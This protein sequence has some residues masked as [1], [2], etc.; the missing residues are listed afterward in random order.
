MSGRRA[1]Q[2]ERL[3][4]Y[5]DL[6]GTS[7]P[8]GTLAWSRE[9]R[10]AYFEFQRDFLANP[11][12]VSPFKLATTPGVIPASYGPFDGL[13]GL[14]SDS[15]PDGWG[16][17]LLDRRLQAGGLDYRALTPLDR[18][19]YVGSLGMGA[20]RYEPEKLF[21]QR[22]SV[23]INLDVI[24]EQADQVQREV[25][26][27]DISVLLRA[28]GGSGGV[29]PKLMIGLSTDGD[30]A[31]ADSGADLPPGFARWIVKFRSLDETAGIGAEEYAYSL[32]ARAAGI[33]MAETRLIE[34]P[35]GRYFATRRFDRSPVGRHHVHTASGLLETS[36]KVPGIGYDELLKLTLILTRDMTHVGQMFRRMAFNVLAHN[37]DDHARNHAF[38]MSSTGVWTPSPAY[39]LTFSSGPAG[40]HNLTILGEGR[41][42]GRKHMLELARKIGLP[43]G[44]AEAIITDIADTVARWPAFADQAGLTRSR[45]AEISSVIARLAAR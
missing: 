21:G 18:L 26:T 9:E 19:A 11:L 14:F 42:P 28:Q 35:K 8:L 34:T 45:S 3:S 30:H 22:S 15:L 24:A 31:L 43:R 32:M 25:A 40:E 29:R 5:L 1:V 7:R 17:K 41:A 37:R 10:R 44:E 2:V 12:P 27:A 23:G 33:E 13:H 6:D 36:H 4:V 20:L 16:Q 39:D 38:L